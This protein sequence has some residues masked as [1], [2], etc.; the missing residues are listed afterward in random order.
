M[1]GSACH[2][3]AV[4]HAV[5]RSCNKQVDVVSARVAVMHTKTL[6]VRWCSVH[7][8]TSV[9]AMGVGCMLGPRKRIVK[10]APSLL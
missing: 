3:G 8:H 6:E 10:V 9:L 7:V 1:D 4:V 2:P 5:T